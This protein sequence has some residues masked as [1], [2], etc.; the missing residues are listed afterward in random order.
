MKPLFSIPP[1]L[2]P[3]KSLITKNYEITQ[4]S[5]GVGINGKVLECIDKITGQ[6][7]ALKVSTIAPNSYFAINLVTVVCYWFYNH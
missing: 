6:K 4:K 2:Q 1:T 3:K 5:L 7:Y